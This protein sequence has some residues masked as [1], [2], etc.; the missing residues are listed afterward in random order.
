MRDL[1]TENDYQL[2]HSQLKKRLMILGGI[3]LV[4]L[5]LLIWSF[6]LDNGKEN[7]PELFTTLVVL[8]WGFTL[9]FSWDLLCKPLY[10]YQK[11]LMNALHGRSHEVQVEFSRRNEEKSVVDGVTYRDLIFL[12]EAD[13]HGDR[14]RMFYWDSQLPDPP[15]TPGDRVTLRYYDRFITGYS[16]F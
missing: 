14:D 11:F 2:I 6:M 13:K 1:Y 15:F 3:S 9:I 5:G 10:C 16:E 4:F 12:G 8:L 7:R